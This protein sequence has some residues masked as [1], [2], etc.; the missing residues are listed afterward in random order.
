MREQVYEK[1][2]CLVEDGPRHV[3]KRVKSCA[4]FSIGLHTL[5]VLFFQPVALRI[6]RYAL[7]S[8]ALVTY[9]IIPPYIVVFEMVSPGSMK[10]QKQ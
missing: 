7:I 4:N 8:G 1:D 9:V 6:V 3:L 2:I 10:A 5:H